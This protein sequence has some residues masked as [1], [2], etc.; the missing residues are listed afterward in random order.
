MSTPNPPPKAS[1]PQPALTALGALLAAG[2]LGWFVVDAYTS[3]VVS[4]GRGGIRFLRDSAPLQFWAMEGFLAL[5]TLLAL[6][7]V[8]IALRAMF[9]PDPPGKGPDEN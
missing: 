7:G 4:L 8:A 3:G 9:R 5:M 1:Q 6:G 2:A